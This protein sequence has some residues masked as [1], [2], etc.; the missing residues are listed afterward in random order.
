[1]RKQFVGYVLVLILLNVVTLRELEYW[2]WSKIKK[3]VE[4]ILITLDKNE[5]IA[6]DLEIDAPFH[7]FYYA[8][9]AISLRAHFWIEL[10]SFELLY[11]L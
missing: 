10:N 2:K 3:E 8:I 7:F 5:I 6:G 11:F 4:K 9:Y 1:M